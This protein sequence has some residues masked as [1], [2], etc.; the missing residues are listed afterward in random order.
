MEVIELPGERADELRGYLAKDPVQNA[1]ALGVLEEHGLSNGPGGSVL[2]FALLEEGR[3]MGTAVVGGGG[4]LVLPCVFDPGAA[5]DL[6]EHMRGRIR[7]RGVFGERYAV[8]AL[9]R[10]F[11]PGPARWSR[12][13]RLYAASADDLGPFVCPELRLA[14]PADLPQLVSMSAAAIRESLGEDPLAH[15]ASAFERRVEARIALARTFVLGDA[16][17]LFLKVDVGVKSRYG[18][19][20]EGLYTLPSARRRGFATL[21]LGQLSRMLLSSSP[22]VV[23]RVDEKDVGLAGVCRKVGFTSMRPQRLVIIG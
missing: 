15:N 18:A 22:R 20:I 16:H 5:A 17:G 2:A 7:L 19:E 3:I 4:G 21:A 11:G 12:P 14:T 9:V 6:G 10:A 8:D 23:M 1:Y 13:Q